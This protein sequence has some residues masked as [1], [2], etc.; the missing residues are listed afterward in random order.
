VDG[1][2]NGCET[3]EMGSKH[4]YDVIVID[5]QI[6]EMDGFEATAEIRRR[7]RAGGMISHILDQTHPSPNAAKF[8]E[9]LG[10]PKAS[11]ERILALSTAA[12]VFT[13]N[14]V[15]GR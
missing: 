2:S 7:E 13:A 11:R 8:A 12:A 9:V 1:A 15:T 4:P 3:V 5:R 6:P 14:R 10:A